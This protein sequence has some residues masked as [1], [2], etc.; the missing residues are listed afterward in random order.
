MAN[1]T[2][3]TIDAVWNK[4]R[5]VTPSQA[6][7]WRKDQCDAWILRSGYGDRNSPYGWE[8]DHI[9]PL[10]KG[11]DQQALSNLRPLHWKNNLSKFDG[12][13]TCAVTSK[14]TINIDK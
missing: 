13:L 6:D 12:R 2:K 11:G 14:G 7:T 1:F 8:I 9:T 4:A 3:E 10:S 5:I